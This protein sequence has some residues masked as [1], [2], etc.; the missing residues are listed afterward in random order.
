MGIPSH[1]PCVRLHEF[2]VMPNHLHGIVEIAAEKLAQHAAPLQRRSPPRDRVQPSSLSAIVRSFK[3]EVTRRARLE[4][5]WK[6]EIWQ[7]N[8]FDRVIRD[9]REFANAMRY[10]A[11]NPGKWARDTENLTDEKVTGLAQ[12]AAPLQGSRSALKS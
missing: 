8:Y 6:G 10:I 1:F 2:V 5:S 4:S 3:S 7:H 12:H 9:G 11:E